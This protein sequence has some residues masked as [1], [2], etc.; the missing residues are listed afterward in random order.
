MFLITHKNDFLIFFIVYY[1][2]NYIFIIYFG[3]LIFYISLLVVLIYQLN[4]LFLFKE[5]NKT[6]NILFLKKQN[7]LKQSIFKSKLK[8]FKS[9]KKTL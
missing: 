9:K 7:L 1:Q 5:E 4:K 8:F 3:F 6:K 2:L